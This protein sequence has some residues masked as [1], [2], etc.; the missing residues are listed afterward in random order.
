MEE[1]RKAMEARATRQVQATLLIEKISQ[2]ENIEVS[3]KE[4]Q[5]RIDHLVRAAGDKAKT[6]REVYSRPD[7]REDL[8]AQIISDRTLAFLLE[9]A[10]V[11][12]VDPPVSKVDEKGKKS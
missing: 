3:D 8:R 12:E 6:V 10:A 1:T 11:K 9:R 7:A 5:E 4:I 2:L